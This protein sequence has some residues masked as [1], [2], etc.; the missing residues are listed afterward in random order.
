VTL[1]RHAINKTT[2]EIVY[3]NRPEGYDLASGLSPTQM[4]RTTAVPVDP[5]TQRWNIATDKPRAATS[6]EI[7]AAAAALQDADAQQQFDG[8]RAVKAALIAA[9][10]GRLGHQPTAAEIAAERARFIAIYKGLA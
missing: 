1:F 8:Q 2:G 9:L 3:G 7:A 10:W 5:V 4:E 6:A